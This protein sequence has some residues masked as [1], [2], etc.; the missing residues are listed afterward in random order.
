MASPTSHSDLFSPSSGAR[1][2]A[3]PGS[4]KA[5]KGIPEK[6]LYSQV[7]ELMHMS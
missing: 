4:A 7:K 3:C 1:L 2:I 5:S 6:F